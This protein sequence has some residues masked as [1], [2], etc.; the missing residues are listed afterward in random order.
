MS[1]TLDWDPCIMHTAA[2]FRVHWPYTVFKYDIG[3]AWTSNH[4]CRGLVSRAKG[5]RLL[6]VKSWG[7]LEL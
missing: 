2:A 4:T 6:E 7:S 1:Q 5:S 3:R